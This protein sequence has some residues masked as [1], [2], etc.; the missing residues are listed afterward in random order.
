MNSDDARDTDR[1]I[2]RWLRDVLFDAGADAPDEPDDDE[3]R[4]RVDALLAADAGPRHAARRQAH[5]WPAAACAA[6]LVA[7]GVIAG[8]ARRE[9]PSQSTTEVTCRGSETA[10]GEPAAAPSGAGCAAVGAPPMPPPTASV[11]ASVVAPPPTLSSDAPVV[12]E[13]TSFDGRDDAVRRSPGV[14]LPSDEVLL[15]RLNLLT[16]GRLD[17]AE[18]FELTELV[19]SDKV[20]ECLSGAGFELP[21]PGQQADAYPSP[22]EFAERYGFGITAPMLG[23]AVPSLVSDPSADYPSSLDPAERDAYH[24][25]E[26]QCLAAASDL[27]GIAR[28]VNAER[29]AIEQLNAEI[30]SDP[31]V[32]AAVD[33]W[34]SC[35]SAAGYDFESMSEVPRQFLRASHSFDGTQTAELQ[36]L[37]DDEIRVATLHVACAVPHREAVRAAVAERFGDYK[38]AL[39]AAIEQ[40]AAPGT[41]G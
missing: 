38:Q 29:V 2:E 19:S 23:I 1:D 6:L 12:V 28:F 40:E 20:S 35:M 39:I 7:G 11:A 14:V 16:T 9:L 10:R 15:A 24:H 17:P 3:V 25:A 41:N 13:T 4:R 22:E 27:D 36:R 34:Q 33:E 18:D 21:E 5:R 26:Q 37:P 8:L 31:A 32:V 30:D